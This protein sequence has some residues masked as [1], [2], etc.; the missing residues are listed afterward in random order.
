MIRNS[1]F[2]ILILSVSVEAFAQLGAPVSAQ[3][4]QAATLPLSGRSPQNGSVTAT[5][6]A[7]P[8]TTTSVNTIN[9]SIQVQGPYTGSSSS[10]AALPFSGKLSLRDSIERGIAY[11]LGPI[12]FNEILRQARAQSKISRS[13]LLPNITGSVTEAVEETNLRAAGLRIN[14]PIPGFVF[15]TVVGPFNYID[16]RA[17]LTQTIFDPTA[18]NNYRTT[19]EVMRADQFSLDDARDL[20]VLAVGGA[21]LQVI[22][23]AARVDA[24]RAQLETANTL[25]KQT[26][27]QRSVG[28]VA[29]IDVNRSQVQVLTQQQRLSSLEND[30][31]KQKINLARLTGLPPNDQYGLTDD[32]AFS[33]APPLTLDVALKQAFEQRTDLKAAEAQVRAA[34]RNRAAARAGRLPSLLVSGDY[35]AIGVN[36]PQAVRTFSVVGTLRIPIWEGGRTEGEIQQAD[37]VLS[38]RKAELSDLRGKIESDVRNA[39]LD[40][41]AASNQIDVAQKNVDV[42][43]ETLELTRQKLEAGVSDNLAVVQSQDAVASARLDYINSLF[44]HN[45]AKLA[46]ARAIGRAAESWPQFLTVK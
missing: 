4:S 45:V 21:Y 8:G 39:F 6:S 36:P 38:Q 14:V 18:L 28:L 44:A 3:G 5:Q 27:D 31:A 20:T 7:I 16:F 32:I 15:P 23:A 43:D 29:Q 24:G 11:N 35:G 30:L 26:A 34:E 13:A 1:A 46:L 19:Q 2:L 40:L 10:T 33:A 25:Y 22:A 17:R 37:A 12:G 42:N 41:Q 9:P